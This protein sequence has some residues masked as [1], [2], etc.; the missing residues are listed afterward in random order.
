[1]IVFHD[2]VNGGGVWHSSRSAYV[3]KLWF[4]EGDAE[5]VIRD[6]AELGSTL[7]LPHSGNQPNNQISQS[8][9]LDK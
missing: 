7:S 2:R 5:L 3:P 8:N 4:L 9:T 1:M 6:G